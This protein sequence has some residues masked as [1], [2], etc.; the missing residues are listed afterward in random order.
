M[1]TIQKFLG[2]LFLIAYVS[3]GGV[4]HAATYYVSKAGNNSNSGTESLPFL[5][6]GHGV[7]RMVAGDTLLIRGGVYAESLINNVPS[8]TSWTSKVQIAAYPGET[9]WMRPTSGEYVIYLDQTQQYIEFDGINL[10]NANCQYGIVKIE[11]WSGGNPH[12]IRFKNAELV[13]SGDGINNQG[14]NGSHAV[15]ATASAAGIVGGNEFINLTVHGHGDPGDFA[16]AYYIQSS[17]NLIEGGNIYDT[18]GYGIQLYNGYGYALNNN[19]IR[20]NVIHDIVTSADTRFAGVIVASGSGTKLYNNLVYGI[21]G[22]PGTGSAGIYLYAGSATEV[23]N[24]TVYGGTAD[25]IAIESTAP[26]A[27]VRNNISYNNAGGNY[28]NSSGST[29]A[30]NNLIGINPSFVN[31]GAGDF[32]PQSGSPAIDAAIAISLVTTDFAGTLRPQ[33][34]AYDIGAYEFRVSQSPS[35]PAPPTG[36]RI[37]QK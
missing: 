6:I 8:G 25:G 22:N 15:I 21:A 19:I 5:T 1:K 30:A 4:A 27:I 20:R 34:N 37:L 24:N 12:H 10:D 16:Y 31:A 33:G 18:G 28:R 29:T 23:Y 7:S 9:V 35:P 13:Y 32:R 36:V 17:D 14:L 11:G 26:N 3:S 2:V